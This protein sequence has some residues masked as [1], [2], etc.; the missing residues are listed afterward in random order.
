[1]VMGKGHAALTKEQVEG[2]HINPIELEDFDIDLFNK[3]YENN[4]TN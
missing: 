3:Y 1:M 2:L 4:S